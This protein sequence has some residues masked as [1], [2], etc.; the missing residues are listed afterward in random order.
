M[1]GRRPSLSGTASHLYSSSSVP[2]LWS[3]TLHQK[4]TSLAD[5]LNM[6]KLSLRKWISSM[7]S[8]ILCVL[9]K[10]QCVCRD[11]WRLS[12]NL[13]SNWW[14]VPHKKLSTLFCWDLVTLSGAVSALWTTV[15]RAW[16]PCCNVSDSFICHS[17][18][19]LFV[20]P[21]KY[22]TP[23]LLQV[24]KYHKH[25]FLHVHPLSG[26]NQFSY[27]YNSACPKLLW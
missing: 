25:L 26:S 10:L 24:S 13:N 16:C 18:T 23:V 14:C 5:F 17:L 12:N 2:H 15:R 3:H 6:M 4:H 21:L 9:S 11:L 22:L 8:H 7:Y 27:K 19:L 1:V 20:S